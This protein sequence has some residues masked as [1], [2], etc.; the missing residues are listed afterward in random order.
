VS[1][2]PLHLPAGS[3]PFP[4]PLPPVRCVDSSRDILDREVCLGSVSK[5]LEG[6]LQLVHGQR[7]QCVDRE[8]ITLKTQQT[9]VLKATGNPPCDQVK[10][11]DGAIRVADLATAYEN[12]DG[13]QRG[14]HGGDFRWLGQGGL[15]AVGTLSG[16]TNVG[17]L[18]EPVFKPAC[19]HCN[20]P[21]VMEG[22]LCGVI[23]RAPDQQRRLIGCQLF[24]VYR[25]LFDPGGEGGHGAIRGTFEGVVVC[26]CQTTPGSPPTG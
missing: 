4:I 17:I 18:R 2:P 3:F 15:L 11:L 23:Q 25:F 13:R 14:L 21:G 16:M 8:C 22:R 12:G 7:E 5:N 6:E 26:A 9:L 20:Q 19:E 1:T 10:L 24:G